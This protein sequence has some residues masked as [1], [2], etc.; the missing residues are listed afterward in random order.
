MSALHDPAYGKAVRALVARR[1]AIGMTQAELA[2]KLRKPQSYVSK[3]ENLER[4]LDI[5]EFL[6]IAKALDMT[7]RAIVQALS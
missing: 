5:A 2:A 1:L 3:S 6:R 7:P 4:R